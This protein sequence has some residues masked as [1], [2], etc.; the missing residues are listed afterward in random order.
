MEVVEMDSIGPLPADE[1]GNKYILTVIC[2]FTRWVSLYPLKDLTAKCC[3]ECL[4][5]HVGTFGTQSRIMTD[6]GT[7]FKNKL[8]EDLLKSMGIQHLTILA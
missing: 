7:Q 5:K 3:A 2:C 1:D 6:N 4:L 8:V